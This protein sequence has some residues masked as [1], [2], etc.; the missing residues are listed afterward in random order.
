[1]LEPWLHAYREALCG[2]LPLLTKA[3]HG[4]ASGWRKPGR[5]EPLDAAR[6]KARI[7]WDGIDFGPVGESRDPWYALAFR[8]RDPLDQ[9]FERLAETLLGPALDA[10]ADDEEDDA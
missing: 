2:P 9:R 3:S 7:A 5:K 6:S 4:F 8:D 1:M 10:L